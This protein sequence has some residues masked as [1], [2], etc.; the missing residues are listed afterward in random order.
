MGVSDGEFGAPDGEPGECGV[1]FGL[2]EL[3]LRVRDFEQSAEAGAVAGLCLF[4]HGPQRL[5][6]AWDNGGDAAG[7][8]ELRVGLAEPAAEF[9]FN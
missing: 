8:I 9:P 6:L 7:A 1:D 5:Y 2:R 4:K 3:A